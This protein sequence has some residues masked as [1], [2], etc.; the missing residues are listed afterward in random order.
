MTKK[1][2]WGI[3]FAVVIA[4]GGASAVVTRGGEN[5]A[6]RAAEDNLFRLAGHTA[7]AAATRAGFAVEP[8]QF[9]IGL[10]PRGRTLGS[11]HVSETSH[12]LYLS[13][14]SIVLDAGLYLVELDAAGR[15]ALFLLPAVQGRRRTPDRI[16][17][18]IPPAPQATTPLGD[19]LCEEAPD[20]IMEFCQ[21][22]VACAAYDLFC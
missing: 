4:V 2:T 18:Q 17:V 3:A 11:A 21:S 14:D 1:L 9:L 15:P 7:S 6:L 16:Q 8:D 12:L 5:R 20:L 13:Q 19:D 22:F 10:V